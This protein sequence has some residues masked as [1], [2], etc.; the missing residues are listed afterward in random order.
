MVNSPVIVLL[1]VPFGYM[2]RVLKKKTVATR[3]GRKLPIAVRE[4]LT[5]YM[6]QHGKVTTDP[7]WQKWA[8]DK[9][10]FSTIAGENYQV[11]EVDYVK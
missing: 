11:L 6:F 5:L 7:L 4:E 8:T 9:F 1:P 10:N 2:K 3:I